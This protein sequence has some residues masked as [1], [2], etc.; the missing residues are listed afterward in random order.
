MA[1]A[2][3]KILYVCNG[4]NA[5]SPLAVA[6]T[7][8]AVANDPNGITWHVDSAGTEAV[9]GASVRPEAVVAAASIGLDIADH[10][11]TALEA[12][13]CESPDLILAMSWDQVSHIWSLVPEAWDKVFTVKEFVH[14]A[15]RAP[16]RPPILFGSKLEE[17]RDKI[18]QAHAIRKRA[19]ADYGFWG[20]IRP[21][22]LN[23]ID[24]NGKGQDA[25]LAL[26]PAMHALT[27]DVIT[28]LRGPAV[29][30]PTP[31]RA[32]ARRAEG[33]RKRTTAARSTGTA[34]AAKRKPAART[35]AKARR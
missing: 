15:K 20:G 12:H 9:E 31:K 6:C 14:W 22:D 29:I 13:N 25:W 27:S 7:R 4:N 23:L 35:R 33:Q 5:R 32:P 30:Q 21:Q 10:R 1:A 16:A 2:H 8:Q 11:A 26:A 34:K 17:M 18:V 28:L 3:F 19:R 24:P